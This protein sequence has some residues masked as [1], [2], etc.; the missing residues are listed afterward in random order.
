[1]QRPVSNLQINEV[2]NGWTKAQTANVCQELLPVM[3]GTFVTN[4]KLVPSL[5]DV[6]L[7]VLWES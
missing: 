4:E 3:L 2:A 1:M 7:K 5:S 6:I